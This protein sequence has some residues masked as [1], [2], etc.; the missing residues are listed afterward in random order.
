MS[1]K[2]GDKERSG[3]NGKAG[4]PARFRVRRAPGGR[5]GGLGS[6][7]PLALILGLAGALRGG[8]KGVGA[9]GGNNARPDA[10]AEKEE[11]RPG[12]AAQET[13]HHPADL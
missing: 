4:A 10:R 13:F 12:R 7:E 11:L 9:D 8:R 3:R 1:T 2:R 5:R 6:A